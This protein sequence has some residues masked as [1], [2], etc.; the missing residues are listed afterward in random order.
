VRIGT[1]QRQSYLGDTQALARLLEY[2]IAEYKPWI[3]EGPIE[4]RAAAFVEDVAKRA[5]RMSAQWMAAG[6]VHGVL[7]SDNI[8]ITGESFDYGPW[9]FA[10]VFNP[11]FTAAYFDEQGLYAFGRQPSAVAWNVTRLA[12]CLVPLSSQSALEAALKVYEPT[13]QREFALALLRRLGLKPSEPRQDALFAKAVMDFMMKSKAP[14]EQTFF[15]WY[16]GEA[17]TGRAAL[18]PSADFYK[19]EAFDEFLARMK[20]HD[21]VDEARLHHAYF[22][23]REPCGMLIDE[24]EAIWKPIAET[25]DW[26]AF[27]GKLARIGVMREAY[28][29]A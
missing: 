27:E 22:Q 21:S 17:S 3:P 11:N 25:D 19:G 15:D 26:S 23:D 14:F 10:P 12:E 6:F 8:N 18:S 5:A 20:E 2:S 29:E 9:R 16:C 4:S 13:V 28:G 1:F 24:V 7:N